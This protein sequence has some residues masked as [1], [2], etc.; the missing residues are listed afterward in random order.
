MSNNPIVGT[1][2]G[3]IADRVAELARTSPD[4]VAIRGDGQRVSYTELVTRADR[5]AARLQAAGLAPEQ[6]VGVLM[7]RSP[8]LV[9]A[10]LGI[11]RAGGAYLALDPSD[12]PERRAAIL[13]SAEVPVLVA[14]DPTA[15]PAGSAGRLTVLAAADCFEP[16]TG[17]FDPPEVPADQLAYIAYTSGST[18]AP[19]GV[20][21]PHRAV[22][23]LVLDADFLEVGPD[24]V[25]LQYAPVA[26]DAST[27]EIWGPL[28]TGGSL[29]IAPPGTLSAVELAD[30]VRTEQISVLW[31]TAGL[32][33]QFVDARPEPLPGLRYLLA[34][35]DVLST[36][37]VERCRA[38]LPNGMVVN[39][40]GPT[41]NTTFT[42]C[43]QVRRRLDPA[44]GVPI[45]VPVS[46]GQ[47]RVLDEE[48]RPV[49]AGTLFAAGPGL[50]RGYLGR[51]DLTAERFLPDPGGEPGSR[52]YDTGDQVSY[53]PDGSLRFLGRLD[54]Q[55]KIRGFRVEPGEAEAAL[56]RHPGIRAAAVVVTGSSDGQRRLTGYFVSN[57]ELVPAEVRAQLAGELPAYLVP[58]ELC[59][60]DELPIT[61]NG[62]LDRAALA[63]LGS[64]RIRDVDSE[65]RA[66]GTELEQWL[67]ELWRELM[68]LDR[69]GVDDDFFELGGHSLLA[70][71]ITTEI[72]ETHD[73]FISA[74]TFYENPTVAELAVQVAAAGQP[75]ELG[76]AAQ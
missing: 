67:A 37:H 62:K 41:E 43:Y 52:M 27:L 7:H 25:Y 68:E 3:S 73:V 16:V 22:L 42:C 29:V 54:D 48:L 57:G 75:V 20:C 23:S 26:F 5:L 38:L 59:R 6:P 10:L 8:Q 17:N 46:G 12:P 28:L 47:V 51:P 58:A 11:L 64:R 1:R 19:K 35:G 34:G 76:G 53:L 61:A 21:I 65:Y 15:V 66:P 45:G 14:D 74:R 70:T 63:A 49:E 30:L 32:F 24:D 50:A 56:R 4:A 40:Y 18:G 13:R 31:L 36:P 39:G 69:V 2:A 44:V 55:V 71:R 33:H 72:A 60:L 9:C